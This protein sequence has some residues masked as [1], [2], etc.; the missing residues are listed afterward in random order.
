MVQ[1][2]SFND[3]ENIRVNRHTFLFEPGIT[4][5]G[6]WKYVKAQ[7]QYGYTGLLNNSKLDFEKYN[8]T[9][10]L[11]IAIAKRYNSVKAVD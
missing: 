9:I 3:I 7:L 1:Q 10:G 5:R 8:I 2:I 6:G 4:I 11:N